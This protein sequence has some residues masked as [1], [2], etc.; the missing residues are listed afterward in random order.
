MNVGNRNEQN[1]SSAVV[2]AGAGIGAGIGA[3]KASKFAMMVPYSIGLVTAFQNCPQFKDEYIKAAEDIIKNNKLPVKLVSPEDLP[4][5][6]ELKPKNLRQKILFKIFNVKKNY[7]QALET[8]KLGF[9]AFFGSGKNIICVNKEK[10]MSFVFHEL[11]H[12][13]NHYKQ[14]LWSKMK[15]LKFYSK[16]APFALL[17]MALLTPKKSQEA[18]EKQGIIGKTTTFIKENVGKLSALVM[19]PFLAE[20]LSASKIGNQFARKYFTGDAL[21]SV[22]KTNKISA[23]S[24]ISLVG[25]TGV[26]AYIANKVRDMV[27]DLIT[28]NSK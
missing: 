14:G 13:I 15:A 22:L 19:L 25:I 11:G 26:S 7:K 10:R 16:L 8:T 1:F 6:L 20:E 21:K 28:K 18:K 9:N 12:A 5:E 2:G 4:P 24:Y 3:Y 17:G 27:S 23:L